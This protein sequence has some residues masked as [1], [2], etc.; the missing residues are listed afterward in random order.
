MNGTGIRVAAMTLVALAL[1]IAWIEIADTR[2]TEYADP[3]WYFVTASNIANGLGMTVSQTVFGEKQY[4]TGPGGYEAVRWPPGYSLTLG[5]FFFVFG[6]GVKTGLMLNAVVGA[7]LVPVTFAIGRQLQGARVGFVAAAVVMLYPAHIV[8]TSVYYSDLLF[9]LPF[10]AATLLILATQSK[11]GIVAAVTVG[12]LIGFAAI[13]R[14]QA[15]ILVPIAGI[16]WYL[17]TPERSRLLLKIGAVAVAAGT[18]VGIVSAWNSVRT[19]SLTLVSRNFGYNLR[20]GHAP[21]STGRYLLPE[22]LWATAVSQP[23]TS[24]SLPD[25]G[26]ATRRAISYAVTHPLKE[27]ELSVRKV[28]YLYTTDSDALVWATNFGKN[29]LHSSQ[30]LTSRLYDLMDVIAIAFLILVAASLPRTLTLHRDMLLPWLIL[31]GWTGL[32]IVFFGEPRYRL[33]ILPIL[34]T[35]AGVTIVGIL[36][37]LSLSNSGATR[38][39]D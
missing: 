17:R 12:L 16:F 23:A 11:G 8:W 14:P 19:D 35:F 29:P 18:C 1:R 10:A 36:D 5:S 25:E 38:S 28:Y 15:L 4:L 3:Q 22:D 7:A 33:P 27:L 37:A 13:I 21:Y 30:D 6:T 20:I 39:E 9:A 31:A 32:H 24:A 26:I 2:L 34:A